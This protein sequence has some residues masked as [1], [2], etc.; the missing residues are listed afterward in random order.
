[1]L[2]QMPAHLA[3][4]LLLISGCSGVS[5]ISGTVPVSGKVTYKDQAV[6]GATVSF[7]GAGEAR[8]ATAITAPD[9]T[10]KL[11]TLDAVGAMPGQYTVVVEKTEIPPELTKSQSME[12]AAAQGN[13]P[14]PQPKK[15]L[16]AKY[17]DPAKTPL[18]FEVKTGQANSFDLVLTD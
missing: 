9:G 15:L 4:V 2:R 6:A 1:M 8:P 10:Y 3:A 17:G 14:L 16:P 12:E 7:L 11:M 5:G 13:Q 18:K